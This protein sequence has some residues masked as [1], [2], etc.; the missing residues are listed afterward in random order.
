M[1]RSSGS[2]PR[3]RTSLIIS[4][5]ARAVGPLFSTLSLGRGR[6]RRLGSGGLVLLVPELRLP[7][8]H[9]V[10]VRV[11]DPRELAVLVRFRALEDLDAGRP[12]VREELVE[13]ID[14]VVDHE[15]RVA[16]REP[17]GIPLGDVPDGEAAI[18]GPVVRLP[19]HGAAPRLQRYPQVLLIP[20]CQCLVVPLALEEH[21]ANAGHPRH[22]SP[23]RRSMRT[24]VWGLVGTVEGA[25]PSRLHNGGGSRLHARRPA[26]RL[27]PGRLYHLMRTT[28]ITPP[29]SSRL[30]SREPSINSASD[31]PTQR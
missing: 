24:A 19:Q 17:R 22:P 4:P 13:V 20:Y 10:A 26:P 29:D 14:S 21:A 2:T 12:K 28:S 11:R 30:T 7:Q 3:S 27:V 6:A 31:P 25:C 9:L 18:L 1:G 5:P 8:L 16:G 15:R 23:P